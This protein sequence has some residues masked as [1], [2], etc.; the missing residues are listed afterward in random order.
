MSG[1][2][3]SHHVRR[4]WID[5]LL[6]A[7][8]G[9]AF[10]AG[11]PVGAAALVAIGLA[12]PLVHVIGVRGRTVDRAFRFAPTEL[13]QRHERVRRAAARLGQDATAA[14]AAVDRADD[15]VLEAAAIFGGRPVRGATHRR[16][17]Q[18]RCALLDHL[19][20]ELTDRAKALAAATAEV[21]ELDPLP[22]TGTDRDLASSPSPSSSDPLATA[23]LVL[24]GPLF[25]AWE[26][27]A[28]FVRGAIALV[29]GI[30]L[31]LRTIA[32]LS[33]RA[34]VAVCRSVLVAARRWRDARDRLAVS[35]REA[36]RQF[37]VARFRVRLRLH[38]AW[39]AG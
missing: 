28:T 10:A 32:R 4:W 31:R 33:A 2:V 29:D 1:S 18:Q 6:V 15:V 12:V 27:G 22:T 39:R 14:R 30:A 5:V 34:F 19:T 3:P 37:A 26:L 35:W 23:L 7:V 16:Y 24:L 21:D 20:V 38:R 8:G 25:V 13:A 11:S 9:A 17:V 36:R